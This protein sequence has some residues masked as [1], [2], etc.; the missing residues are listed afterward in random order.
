MMVWQGMPFSADFCFE[1]VEDFGVR[2]ARGKSPHTAL[3]SVPLSVA[4]A[5]LGRI[6][7]LRVSPG[8]DPPSPNAS[9]DKNRAL[10]DFWQRLLSAA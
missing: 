10:Q 6:Q 4:G 3:C 2:A 8:A 7:P 9:E 5:I 1:I